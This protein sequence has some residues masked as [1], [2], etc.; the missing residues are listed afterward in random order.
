MAKKK[1]NGFVGFIDGLPLIVKLLLFFVYVV[2]LIYR[3]FVVIQKP[4]LSS[5]LGLILHFF[6]LG[7]IIDFVS[8]LLHGKLV[9]LV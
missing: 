1:S 7:L 9:W 2:W 4:S 3:I 8:V 6:L 5:L